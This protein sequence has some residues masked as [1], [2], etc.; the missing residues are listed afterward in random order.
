MNKYPNLISPIKIGSLTLR[1]RIMS[2][3]TSL[4]NLTP[5][6][7]PTRE[8]IAYYKLLASLESFRDFQVD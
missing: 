2:A 7:H 6:G 5:A 1:N 3:P 4:A 8:N